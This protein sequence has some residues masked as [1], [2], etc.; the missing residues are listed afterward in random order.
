MSIN[1][2]L[3]RREKINTYSR[4]GSVSYSIILPRNRPLPTVYYKSTFIRIHTILYNVQKKYILLS[5]EFR[6]VHYNSFYNARVQV[7]I[8]DT[9]VDDAVHKTSERQSFG[10]KPRQNNG[11]AQDGLIVVSSWYLIS[12]SPGNV[13]G[14]YPLQCIAT[15]RPCARSRNQRVGKNK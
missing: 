9:L 6:V 5:H 2:I 15:R 14:V 12:L 3:I 13:R 1:C 7:T 10:C 11:V 8:F 4:V